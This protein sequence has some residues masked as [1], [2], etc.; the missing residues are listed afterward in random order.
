MGL[1]SSRLEIT[2]T[3]KR[4]LR[5]RTE[6]F[7]SGEFP[8]AL[9]FLH[10][11]KSRFKYNEIQMD[12][13]VDPLTLVDHVQLARE[14]LLVIKE[15]N[16]DLTNILITKFRI[17]GGRDDIEYNKS[18]IMN[19]ATFLHKCGLRVSLTRDVEVPEKWGITF[20]KFILLVDYGSE[21]EIQ[22]Q[23]RLLLGDDD[24]DDD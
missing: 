13:Y 4:T 5:E 10:T 23:R 24:D 3:D 11:H 15:E 19:L 17:S 16:L 22:R 14:L 12:L 8:E 9:I 6:L 1:S 18:L 21:E 2:Y 7:R 20:G